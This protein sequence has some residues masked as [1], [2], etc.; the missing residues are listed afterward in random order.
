MQNPGQ[1]LETYHLTLGLLGQLLLRISPEDADAAV[2]EV[3]FASW[4]LLSTAQG[5]LKYPGWMTTQ[6]LFSLGAVCLDW[7]S[8]MVY[9]F[10]IECGRLQS[11]TLKK[12]RCN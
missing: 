2:K 5:Q 6:V 8:L 7:Y 9:L 1:L 3:L 12:K 10:V 11:Q 4:T